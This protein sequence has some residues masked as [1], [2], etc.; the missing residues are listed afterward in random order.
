MNKMFIFNSFIIILVSA[1]KNVSDTVDHIY[2]SHSNRL[3]F[4]FPNYLSSLPCSKSYNMTQLWSVQDRGSVRTV[5]KCFTCSWGWYT[6]E[7]SILSPFLPWMKLGQ[8]MM[9]GVL[10]AALQPYDD[11]PQSKSGHAQNGRAERGKVSILNNDFEML[12]WCWKWLLCNRFVM[13]GHLLSLLLKSLPLGD[14]SLV[15]K[16]TPIWYRKEY[17]TQR[18]CS[19]ETWDVSTGRNRTYTFF[20]F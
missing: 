8:G 5:E 18:M 3:P 13:W 14:L 19:R 11:D 4:S 7:E 15:A 16:C 9:C 12:C 20:F 1:P 2:S 17:G 10:I 6:Q